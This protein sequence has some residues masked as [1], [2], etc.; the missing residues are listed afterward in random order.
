MEAIEVDTPHDTPAKA[1]VTDRVRP[2][3]KS[4][5]M[6]GSG[7][8]IRALVE[9]GVEVVFG[10]PGGVVLGLYDEIYKSKSRFKHVL[11]RHEQGGTHAA[12]GYAR[13]T[14]KPGVV[15]VTSGPGAT[16]TVT[17]IA[18]AYMD[19][20]PLVIFTG[21]VAAPLIGNDAFQEADIVGITRP[22]TK[23]S[24]LVKDVVDLEEVVHEAFYIAKSG[25][26]GPVLVDLPKDML[27]AKGDY[28]SR[29]QLKVEGHA[30][31]NQ[32]QRQRIAKAARL[33][34]NAKRPLIYAGGGTIL[35]NAAPE[36][37]ELALK[38][39]IPV[40]TT[41]LGLGGF[42]ES[43]KLSLG[44]LGMH[45]TW[46]A[47]MAISNCDVL[48]AVG[49]RFDD[50]VTGRIDGFS[51]KSKKIHIDIDPACI[52]KNVAVEV[53]IIGDVKDILPEL[54]KLV[55]KPETKKWRRMIAQWQ[56]E[57]PLRYRQCANVIMPQFVI[58]KISEVTRGQAIIVTDV[59][60]HQMWT[61]Q[62]YK[63][64]KPRSFLS[65]GGLGTMGYG[66]PAAMG[67]AIGCPDRE[68]VCITGDGG[69]QMTTFEL[70]T[71]VEHK[72]PVKIAIL[73]NGY[74]GMVRQWQEMFFEGRYS[75]S[76][77]QGGNPDFVKLAQSYGAIGLRTHKPDEVVPILEESLKITNKP[78]VMDFVVAGE[79]NVF[80]MVPAGA[81]LP[82]MV[83]TDLRVG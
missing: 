11:I 37:T 23:H 38:T 36:L 25:R 50:R 64:D 73:N 27:N 75:F 44:M 30:S 14:G 54:T 8:L 4:L 56:K 69:F 40:T 70:A 31:P 72:V 42:P 21:Q 45:G 6:T 12:D 81:S 76:N 16:N 62:Y 67:A 5:K 39:E 74:L 55:E 33:I 71:A 20:I 48:V 60:Q 59:G 24:Y 35:G 52:N 80:P 58:E 19:S 41:L 22:I 13:A 47:N 65:S 17:G 51:T 83:D 68:V 46:Y 7:I 34:N 28:K 1:K 53:P 49:A 63:F 10:Y 79:E 9:E 82:E 26:P 66:L 61:A 29:A 2:D 43:H 57:H 18:T 78:V 77:L 32:I 3:L 15:L